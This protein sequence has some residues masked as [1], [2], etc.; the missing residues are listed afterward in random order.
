M[1]A[2]KFRFTTYIILALLIFL[3][4]FIYFIFFSLADALHEDS[5]IVIFMFGFLIFFYLLVFIWLVFGEL[6]TKAVAVKITDNEIFKKGYLGLGMTKQFQFG[7]CSHIT[8]LVLTSN[9]GSYEY[10]Y[11]WK[12]NKKVVKLSEYY[13]RN[14]SELKNQL[15]SKVEYSGEV[16]F[17]MYEEIK[18]I[19]Q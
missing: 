2:S 7:E 10:L 6:R 16:P 3:T 9:Y 13:H 12:D 8:S 18:E 15:I 19:F 14:Y 5:F 17:I 1:L 4:G 11:L